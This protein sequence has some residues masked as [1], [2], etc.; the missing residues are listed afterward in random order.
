MRE[1]QRPEITSKKTEFLAGLRATLGKAIRAKSSGSVSKPRILLTTLFILGGSALTLR[2]L[3]S[4]PLKMSEDE[5]NHLLD[6][7]TLTFTGK[8]DQLDAS[9]VSGINSNDF[10]MIV[11]V[12]RVLSGDQEALKKFGDLKDSKLTV[13]INPVSRIWMQKDISAV[14]FAEPL[15]YEKNIGVVATAVPLPN[16]KEVFLNK[17]QAEAHR[18]LEAPLRSGVAKAKLIIIGEVVAVRPLA[19]DLR[20]IRNGWEMFSEHRPRWKEA[21]VKLLSP[22]LKP[23]EQSKKPP[24]F[25]SVV[26]PDSHDCMYSEAQKFQPSQSGIWLLRQDQLAKDETDLLIVR[27]GKY[28]GGDVESY[29][30]LLPTDFQELKMRNRIE[31]IVAEP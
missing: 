29:T 4:D 27:P 16:S 8:V 31:Q 13:A 25:V 6:V 23:V 26:F 2:G 21:I 1:L 22:P 18:K 19:V 17:L 5:L 15:I 28:N 24:E 14:F 10:P 30:A 11:R 20:S 3:F 9:N 7:S 12:D